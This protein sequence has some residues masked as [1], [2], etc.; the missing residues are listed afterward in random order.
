[1]IADLKLLDVRAS[2]LQQ[3]NLYGSGQV[4]VL[5]TRP[6]TCRQ[7]NLCIQLH[8]LVTQARTEN[9]A[10]VF[11]YKRD[12]FK[13]DKS[14]QVNTRIYEGLFSTCLKNMCLKGGGGGGW[15]RPKSKCCWR[16]NNDPI[17]KNFWVSW[18]WLIK[19]KV[20]EFWQICL[21]DN[22]QC[23]IGN[24]KYWNNSEINLPSL[25][26]HWTKL[27]YILGKPMLCST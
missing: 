25:E 22:L 20:V 15:C 18:A 17:L 11:W 9:K 27:K 26:L 16:N 2:I 6:P 23:F 10:T 1:M 8:G 5:H 3:V 12:Y 7:D 19:H 4:T 14:G 13:E 24:L 21:V